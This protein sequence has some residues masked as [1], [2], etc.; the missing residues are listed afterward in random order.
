MS[1]AAR[2][3]GVARM[4]EI[5]AKMPRLT[6]T[7]E[8]QFEGS[9]SGFR[10]LIIESNGPKD[11]YDGQLDSIAA[12]GFL[13]ILGIRNVLRMVLDLEHFKRALR[14]AAPRDAKRSAFDVVHLSCHGDE[15][16]IAFADNSQL[17]WAQFAK[18]FS[19]ANC[20]PRALVMSSCCG[21]ASGIGHAF[22][23]VS[24]QVPELFSAQK[25]SALTA[26]TQPPGRCSTTGSSWLA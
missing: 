6:R 24:G 7:G 18:L 25:T 26:N 14:D 23:S 11:F 22:Q 19:E 15:N 9:K 13:D 21:A 16:G 1:E 8:D 2:R 17:E 3:V 12:Q 10:V 20:V 5:L 4:R